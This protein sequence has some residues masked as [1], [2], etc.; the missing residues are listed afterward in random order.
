MLE[1]RPL[2]R[3]AGGVR[4]AICPRWTARRSSSSVSISSSRLEKFMQAEIDY[5]A[6]K[7]PQPVR[8]D[9]IIKASTPQEVANLIHEK[10]PGAFATRIKHL[11]TLPKWNEVPEIQDVHKILTHSFRNLRLVEKGESLREVT[12]VIGDL[13]RRHKKVVPLLGDA[14]AQLRHDD[15]ID[16]S[17][18][19]KWLDTFLLARISTEMLTLHFMEMQECYVAHEGGD[20]SVCTGIVDRKCDPVAICQK[21]VDHVKGLADEDE[22]IDYN[23]VSFIVEG[24]HCTAS[25]G[26]IEFSFL[27]RYL[28]LLT[29]ELLKNSAY[30]TVINRGDDDKGLEPFPVTVTVGSN[31]QQVV[32]K[33]SDRGGGISEVSA[34][35]LWSY[36][37][38]RRLS[39]FVKPLTQL[40]S[41]DDPLEGLKQ[42]RLGMGLPLCRLYTKYM[43]GSL[44]LMSV[45]G[46]GVALQHPGSSVQWPVPGLTISLHYSPSLSVALCCSALLHQCSCLCPAQT[47]AVV[48]LWH[49]VGAASHMEE[50][51]N[52]GPVVPD[53]DPPRKRIKTSR[54]YEREA[55]RPDKRTRQRLRDGDAQ[56]RLATPWTPRTPRPL[57]VFGGPREPSWPPPEPPSS[58]HRRE[59]TSTS[60][61]AEP[62]TPS[63]P[64]VTETDVPEPRTPPQSMPMPLHILS[65]EEQAPEAPADQKVEVECEGDPLPAAETGPPPLS[66]VSSGTSPCQVKL[67]QTMTSS[68]PSRSPLAAPK[69]KKMPALVKGEEAEEDPGGT[70]SDLA[71]DKLIKRTTAAKTKAKPEDIASTECAESTEGQQEEAL[72]SSSSSRP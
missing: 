58:P 38:S 47:P 68:A 2:L 66:E 53:P 15:L 18:A 50:G 39:G 14:I 3:G 13:R 44:Q 51:D 48:L 61:V 4:R 23:D 72:P 60:P 69:P 8:L 40:A 71:A 16:E 57:T 65:D 1:L 46:V 34:E 22:C 56:G 35:K 10:L 7:A 63:P 59:G 29:E 52:E 70:S 12:E 30:A 31:Q 17:F 24:N 64:G 49:I 20:T 28:L 19:N 33:I 36:S 11:E 5:F 37:W 6:Q 42:Q 9:Q 27:P 25:Q 54:D 41:F 62:R 67:E 45:P 55:R 32:I 43:G 21:A 26:K